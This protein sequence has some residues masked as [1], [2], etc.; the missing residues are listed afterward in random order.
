MPDD[1]LCPQR[2]EIIVNHNTYATEHPVPT[3][4]EVLLLAGFRPA[5]DYVL[6]LREDT[7]MLQDINLEDDV[8]VRRPGI[9]RFLAFR[10][11]RLFFFVLDDRRYPW[12]EPTVG[13]AD[14]RQL[15]G[16][17]PVKEIWLDRKHEPD[18]KLEPGV[19]VSLK[20]H[21][22]ERFYTADRAVEPVLVI[23][24][25]NGDPRKIRAGHYTT[26]TL[27]AAL[28]VDPT[29]DLDIIGHDGVF[30]PLEPGEH[31]EVVAGLKFVSH[32]RQGG[33]S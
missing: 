5:D 21:E 30:R 23:V 24:E 11:D 9:E 16:V 29:W 26:E 33:S 14:L 4:R 20:G 7:G 32:V 31:I 18:L 3:G 27:K 13:E 19:T 15:G 28:E 8:D 6:L 10:S 22:V 25:L 2:F 17:P 12:A 1:I